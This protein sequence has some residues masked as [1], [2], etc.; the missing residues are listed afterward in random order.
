MK[1]DYR[2]KGT[3]LVICA[4]SGSGKT[5]LVRRITGHYPQI[6]FSVSYTTR[7]PRPGEIEGKDYFFVS[8]EHFD[9]L[10]EKNFFAE[11]AKVHGNRYGTPLAAS[12]DILD[13]GKDLIFDVDVQ[14]A[15]QLKRNLPGVYM[16]FVLPPSRAALEQRLRARGAESE[17]DI[18]L[19][20]SNAALELEQA[21][22]FDA[23]VVNDDPEKAFQDLC[24]VYRTACMNPARHQDFFHS[25]IKQFRGRAG[26]ES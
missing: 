23:W 9:E 16:V 2:R 25:L 21:D 4:P 11:W 17:K 6:A 24:A 8:G 20:L 15:A 14:G 1:N 3:A 13:S 19:R 26:H 10:A 5:T 18:A 7:P 22:W 12:R